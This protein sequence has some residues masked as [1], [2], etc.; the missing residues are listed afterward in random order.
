MTMA[1]LLGYKMSSSCMGLGSGAHSA[2]PWHYT[3]YEGVAVQH[4]VISPSAFVM[5]RV[6]S[7]EQFSVFNGAIKYL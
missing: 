1:D 4:A 3:P 2:I 6:P 5:C 7:E